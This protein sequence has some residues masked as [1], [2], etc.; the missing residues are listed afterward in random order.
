MEAWI[1]DEDLIVL[2]VVDSF[3]S[4]IWT[5]R[6][7]E[8][9]D[10]ELYLMASQ[11]ALDLLRIDRYVYIKESDRLM[12]IESINLN[13]DPEKGNHLTVKGRSLESLLDRR[14]VWKQTLLSGYLQGQVYKLINQNAINPSDS[15]RA[16]PRLIFEEINNPEVTRNRIRSQYTGD[17]LYEAMV[18]IC[19]DFGIGFK[20]YF[21]EENQ[22]VFR[23]IVP[24]DRSSYQ[25]DNGLVIFSP[26]FDNLIDTQ[27][28][29]NKVNL[30]NVGVVAGEGEG[31]ARKRTII[32]DN[33]L[34]GYERR[35]LFVDA[36]DISSNEGEISDSEYYEQLAQ[37]GSEK[38]SECIEEESFDGSVDVNSSFQYGRDF[39]IGDI[40][41]MENEYGLYSRCQVI[42]YIRCQDSD[43]YTAYPTFTLI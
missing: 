35:E 8:A 5:E 2:G 18:N 12:I 11:S 27:Y 31:S 37:R 32:G 14:I 38:L 36:R 40:V 13:T 4:F 10:F 43:G 24:V 34:S 17:N 39:N 1:L 9:G 15:K 25:L 21:N 28:T 19:V 30:K 22:F 29:F 7:Y 26:E 42:E 3:E 23:L 6:F 20:I 33:N 16:I 41:E